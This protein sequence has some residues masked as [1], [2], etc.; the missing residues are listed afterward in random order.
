MKIL[1]KLILF[2]IMRWKMIHDFPKL[3]KYVIILEPHTSW[4]DFPIAIFGKYIKGINV[5]FVGKASLFKFPFGYF[6]R[7]LGGE[8]IVRTGKKNKVQEIVTIFNNKEHFILAMSPKGTRRLD[9]K[10]RT[11]F[12]YIAKGANVPIVMVTLDF[13]DKQLKISRPYYLTN[14][15]DTDFKFFES[16]FQGI[17]GKF[18]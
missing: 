4:Q 7:M 8:P 13:K 17:Q 10:W 14:N 15:M 16:Y 5:N 9:A 18:N 3:K 1:S 11:G 12:Y 6:F 2:K